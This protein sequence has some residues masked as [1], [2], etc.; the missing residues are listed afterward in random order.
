MR[1]GIFC[2]MGEEGGQPFQKTFSGVS[3]LCIG[4]RVMLQ[5]VENIVEEIQDMQA[6]SA[7]SCLEAM[8]RQSGDVLAETGEIV[9]QGGCSLRGGQD[10]QQKP[11]FR[12]LCMHV[13]SIPQLL[14]ANVFR[15]TW[16]FLGVHW[17]RV[18][19]S[20]E[21]NSVS[22]SRVNLVAS[23]LKHD[24]RSEALAI[25]RLCEAMRAYLYASQSQRQDL[26]K[27][28]MARMG[29]NARSTRQGCLRHTQQPLWTRVTGDSW[30]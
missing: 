11:R 22:S 7:R 21:W 8:I 19:S 15:P 24:A 1:L 25:D 26:L 5:M 28:K 3:L 13:S 29:M 12:V 4:A 9:A 6:S 23:G 14:H 17:D 2:S 30:L 18:K 16:M 27:W 20:R 10:V